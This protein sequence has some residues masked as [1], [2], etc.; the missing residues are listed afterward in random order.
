[1][2]ELIFPRD[3]NHG[4]ALARQARRG[5]VRRVRQGLYTDAPEAGIPGLVRRCWYKLAEHFCSQPLAA[6]RTAVELKP[7]RGRVYVIDRVKHRRYIKVGDWLTIDVI[8][9]NTSLLT[10]PFMP[11]LTRSA[12]PRQLLEN[13]VPSRA[14]EAGHKSLGS[15]WVEEALCKVLAQRGEGAIREIRKQAREAASA[16]GLEKPFSQLDRMIGALLAS[17]PAQGNLSSPL[18]I[19][20]ARKDPYDPER[21][22]LFRALADY[23]ERCRF[24]PV[25]YAYN[26][27]SWRNLSFFESY[28]SNYIEGTEFDISEA[29]K[30]VFEKH[31][32]NSRPEDSH[33]VL[34]VY[35]IVHDYQEMLDTPKNAA[36]LIRLLQDRHERMMSQRPD[37]RPGGFKTKP[38]KAGDTLFVSPRNLPGTITRG[39][40]IY[41][42]LAKGMRRAI[43]IHFLITECHP[44]D[45]GNGRLSRIFLNAELSTGEQFK[46]IVPTVHRD[47]YL[48]GLRQATR[49]GKFRTL[50]KVLFQL[51]QYTASLNWTDYGDVREQLETH[52]AHLLPD[53]GVAAFNRQIVNFKMELP[54]S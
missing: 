41:E 54:T 36:E 50:V 25:P 23:L 11:E 31:V 21:L 17:R 33:D 42:D 22:V 35:D 43:F 4:K 40:K 44:F 9:G 28:F 47:S 52:Q 46:L 16:L 15:D 27:S 38:N 19:A 1:M 6:Y 5:K 18:A 10:E 7:H 51:Q 2:A 53:E 13:L 37:K 48:N 30:I 14:R 49:E 20:T 34:A 3:R 45:D 12:L 29:E 39:F 8:P 24:E 32:V 26:K